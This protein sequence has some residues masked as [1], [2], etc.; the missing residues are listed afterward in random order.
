M[1]LVIATT[2]TFSVAAF[3]LDAADFSNNA[4]SD[5]GPLLSLFGDQV[6]TQFLRQSYTTFDC[7]LFAMGPIGILT[8][9]TAAIRVGKI[10]TLKALI[11]R[12]QESQE[13]VEV[14]VLSSTSQDVCEIWNG[15]ELVRV[16]GNGSVLE[17]VYQEFT[18]ECPPKNID[19]KQ[20]TLQN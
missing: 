1:W 7:I 12:A 17:I 13:A 10:T 20:P 6:T 4:V 11:G 14:E 15:Q 16:Q 8:A 18:S 19:G 3:A 9:I 5:L 2:V